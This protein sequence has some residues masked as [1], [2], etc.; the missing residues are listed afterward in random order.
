VLTVSFAV[1][2][3]FHFELEV[4]SSDGVVHPPLFGKSLDLA[5]GSGCILC[6]SVLLI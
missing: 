4:F 5:P 2:A 3:G 1:Y 6:S